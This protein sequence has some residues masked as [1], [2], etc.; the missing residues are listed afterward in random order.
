MY[1]DLVG[2]L[3][4]VQVAAGGE[5][6]HRDPEPGVHVVVAA[7]VGVARV[8][9]G[10]PRVVEA[11]AVLALRVD[12]LDQVAQLGREPARADELEV[13]AGRRSRCRRRRRG[14]SCRC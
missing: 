11:E 8:A 4:V 12:P 1:C 5:E 10:V 9:V 2:E 13:A 6:R 7:A 14:R 3:V